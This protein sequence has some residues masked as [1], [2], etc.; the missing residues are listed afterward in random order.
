MRADARYAVLAVLGL[1]VVV[2]L[3]VS[4]TGPLLYSLEKDTFPSRFHDNPD[5]L[6][7]Q[8]LNSTGDLIP[9]MQD[10]ADFNGPVVLNIRIRD[11]EQVQHD[12]ELFARSHGS[13]NSLIVKL[14]MNESEI[15]DF[16]TSSVRQMQLL[17]GL[18]NASVSF[19]A[20]DRLEIQYRDQDNP[21]MLTS[22][23]LQK[24]TIRKKVH[25]LYAQYD[26]ESEKISALNTKFGVNNTHQEQGR[27]E[28]RRIVQEID[29]S[30][31]P[32]DIPIRRSSQLT[33]LTHPDTG[34]YGD[35][36]ECLGYLF[37]LYGYRVQGATNASVTVYIDNSPV[38]AT[39]T[40]ELG[41]YTV[42]LPIERVSAGV[43]TLHA[44]SGT[45][46]S[47]NRALTVLPVDSVTM[48]SVTVADRTGNVSCTGNVTANLPVRSAPVKIV[49]DQTNTTTTTTDS[50]GTFKTVVQLPEGKHT[51]VAQFTGEGFPIH[52]SVSAVQDVEVSLAP[53]YRGLLL[54]SVVISIFGLFA[55]GA[56]YYLRRM[57][58]TTWRGF[59]AAPQGDRMD[60]RGTD[61]MDDD[62]GHRP[63]EKV[64]EEPTGDSGIPGTESLIMRYAR[65]LQKEGLSAAARVVYLALSGHIARELHIEKHRSLTP[66]ELS[67][68]CV[69]KPY[70]GA[71]ASFVAVYERIRYG[72]MRS[73][74]AQ[75]E[76]ESGMQTAQTNIGGDDH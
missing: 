54:V 73:A 64:P 59:P 13:L 55:S 15:K 2:A 12:L 68:S 60:G 27:E 23:T 62:S 63:S 28:F 47:E 52:P 57:P 46:Q 25:E 4:V 72:G 19:D 34:R 21:N 33:L 69:K 70:C 41:S 56:W 38:S 44:Q 5:V 8:E 17:Q 51:V 29:A 22:V 30:E 76:F 14:D 49:W 26:T 48:L 50:R 39:R 61:Q 65:I 67:R 40:D 7:I 9:L 32:V 42:H 18:A 71:F 16:S 43:H 24:D 10:I 11:M 75:A 1:C 31:Q 20:L 66:R 74:A 36:V 3:A 58:G 53:D 35:T 45:T 6:K 37:S